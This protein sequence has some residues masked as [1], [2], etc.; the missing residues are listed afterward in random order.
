LMSDTFSVPPIA[1]WRATLTLSYCAPTVLPPNSTLSVD[2]DVR[3]ALPAKL[4]AAGLFPGE[5]AARKVAGRN[6]VSDRQ[7][8]FKEGIRC[9]NYF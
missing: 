8:Y 6:K 9:Q 1:S 2:V 3:S 4:I 5:R 7:N